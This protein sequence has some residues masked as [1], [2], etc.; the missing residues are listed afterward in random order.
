[1]RKKLPLLPLLVLLVAASCK[2]SNSSTG[3]SLTGSWNLLQIVAHTRSA[4]DQTYGPDD[5]QDVTTSD[6]TTTNNAG[7]ITFTGSVANTSGITYEAN[8][9]AM[10][11]S[12]MDGQFIGEFSAPYDLTIPAT[13]GSS[14]YQQIGSDSLYFP[15]GGVFS[16]G[17]GGGTQT[18][19]VGS[20]FAIR[21]D[22]LALTTT[23]HQVTT[24]NIGGIPTSQTS[25]A[26]ETAYFKKK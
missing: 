9:L 17:G 3:N 6:Y 20:R 25:D 13:S 11:S 26:V 22:T 8:F 23:I 2:K 16:M 7:T 24:Q 5:Y 4:V 1:M 10:D 14:K 21:G 15:A 18:T 12:Y 19:P